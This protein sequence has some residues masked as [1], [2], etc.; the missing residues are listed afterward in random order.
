MGALREICDERNVP[1]VVD[2][3]EAFLCRQGGREVGSYGRCATYSFFANKVMTTGEGGCVTTDDAELAAKVDG[4]CNHNTPGGYWHD[5]PG[6]NFRLTN[7]Q[8]AL[9]V[10]QLEEVDLVVARK[11]HVARYYREHLKFEP[12]VPNRV[13]E[14]SEWMPVWRLPD[15]SYEEFRLHCESRGVEVRPAFYPVHT[16]PGFGGLKTRD[17]YLAESL[18]GRHFMLPC[19]PALSPENLSEIVGVVNSFRAA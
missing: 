17:R 4:F 19:H 18:P 9:G 12:L 8:A 14:S 3:A 1:L 13:E 7:L 2:A 16:M 10:A 5:G 6:T 15:Y 11:R